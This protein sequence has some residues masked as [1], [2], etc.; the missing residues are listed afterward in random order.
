LGIDG[1]GTEDIFYQGWIDGFFIAKAPGL[2]DKEIRE[3]ANL[4]NC[5]S[6]IDIMQAVTIIDKYYRAHPEKWSNPAGL[7]ILQDLTSSG[8]CVGNKSE[9]VKKAGR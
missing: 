1:P 6:T 5:L 3:R 4:E 9:F 2:D 8:P 7:E